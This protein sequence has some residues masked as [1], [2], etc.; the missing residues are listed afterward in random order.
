MWLHVLE[1][2]QRRG[3]GP[4]GERHRVADLG[5]VNFLDA[6][7]DEADAS[8][9]KLVARDRLGRKN[10]DLLAV[11]KCTRR[12]QQNLV[13][14]HER[15]LHHPDQHDDADVVVEPG[16]DDQGLQRGR[17]IAFGRR[18]ACDDRLQDIVD[19]LAGLGAGEDRI[20]GG[21]ADDVLDLGDDPVGIGRR[22]VD[23]VQHRHDR[24][25]LL[26]RGVAV[27]DRLRL[28]ALRSVDDQQ[29][30]LAGGERARNL[31]REVDMA[32]VSIRFRS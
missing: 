22:Q 26:G 16:I 9:R 11:V 1:A 21:N 12:H 18:D 20:V 13:A 17:G 30:A 28:H 32:G 19:A 15:P 7:D 6:G 3:G 5:R 25:A 23:L 14:R 4:R 10:A 2:R 8:R 29:R 24:D 31:V 27:G